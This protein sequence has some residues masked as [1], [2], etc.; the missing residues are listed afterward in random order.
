MRKPMRFVTDRLGQRVSQCLAATLFSV[1]SVAAQAAC[2]L[3]SGVTAQD[4]QMDMGRVLIQPDLPI[5]AIIK[6]LQVP[7]VAKDNVGSCDF[8]GGYALGE[9]VRNPPPVAG[10]ANVFA[11]DVPGIGIRL[12]RE[13]ESVSTYY[14]HRLDLAG[15]RQL[16]LVGGYF[17]VEL[18]KTA[19]VTGSGPIGP[20][21]LFST[22]YLDGSGRDRPIL[23]SSLSGEGTTIVSSSCQVDAGSKNIAVNFGTVSNAS[24]SGVGSR[25]NARDFNITLHCQGGNVAEMDQGLIKVRLDGT[26]DA[27]N[28]Q[29]VLAIDAGAN[30]ATGIGIQL[31]QTLGGVEQ[32]VTLG[33]AIELGRTSANTTNVFTLPMRAYYIQT[34]PGVVGPGT[35][36][37]MA[38]FTIEYH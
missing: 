15:N 6:T 22:Y 35:G 36:N 11:T 7:I 28:M 38:T 19:A 34:Q 2:S 37:G 17:K 13:A 4:I 23:T 30:S 1:M 10:F 14:P 16:N 27:S 29:G 24:F 3:H 5:G 9:L 20:P 26:Q 12:Y 32:T 8:M 25:M 21:G 31:N 33:E 18:V